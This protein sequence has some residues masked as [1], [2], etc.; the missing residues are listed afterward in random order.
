MSLGVIDFEL[1]VDGAIVGLENTV[2]ALAA[3][4]SGAR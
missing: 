3:E 4:D 2:V 1:V